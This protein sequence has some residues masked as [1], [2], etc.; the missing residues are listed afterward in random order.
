MIHVIWHIITGFVVGLLARALMPGADRMGVI[1]TVCLGIVGSIVGG[2]IGRL[3]KKPEPGS[4][5]HPAGFFLSLI[6]AI[7]VLWLW[8]MVR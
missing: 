7:V 6:G 5:F 8:R 4:T 1:A 3:V 2:F